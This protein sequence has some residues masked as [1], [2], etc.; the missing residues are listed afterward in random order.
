MREG[1]APEASAPSGGET[2]GVQEAG[3]VVGGGEV[4]GQADF[5]ISIPVSFQIPLRGN[6]RETQIKRL[7]GRQFA[8]GRSM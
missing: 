1:E 3:G 5:K 8:D 4:S 7:N 2:G 6:S